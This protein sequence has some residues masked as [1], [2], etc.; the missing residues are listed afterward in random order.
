MRLLR[1][2]TPSVAIRSLKIAHT[3]FEQCLANFKYLINLSFLSPSH[4]FLLL[5]FFFIAGSYR[6][7]KGSHVTTQLTDL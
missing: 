7:L 1:A 3:A 6:D 2:P 4:Y 5:L